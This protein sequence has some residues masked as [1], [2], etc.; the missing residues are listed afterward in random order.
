MMIGRY[1]HMLIDANV[2]MWWYLD[3]ADIDVDE[4]TMVFFT[5]D[6][7]WVILM[8]YAEFCSKGWVDIYMQTYLVDDLYTN[9]HIQMLLTDAYGADHTLCMIVADDY[10]GLIYMFGLYYKCHVYHSM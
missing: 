2:P 5:Y 4:M 3:H 6:I 8:S 10:H 1:L 7:M 9:G